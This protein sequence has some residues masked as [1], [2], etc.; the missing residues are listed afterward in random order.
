MNDEL[1]WIDK[2]TCLCMDNEHKKEMT[3]LL[4]LCLAPTGIEIKALPLVGVVLISLSL[5]YVVL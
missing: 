4:N 5:T 3:I 2:K 1:S